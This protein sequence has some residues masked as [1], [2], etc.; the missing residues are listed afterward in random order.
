[1]K[2]AQCRFCGVMSFYTPIRN[3]MCDRCREHK[4]EFPKKVVCFICGKKMT[5]TFKEHSLR[6]NTCVE[7]DRALTAKVKATGYRT[8]P[9]SRKEMEEFIKTF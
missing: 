8:L 4:K 1:M 2:Q 7:C 6:G 5:M 3:Y 9:Q